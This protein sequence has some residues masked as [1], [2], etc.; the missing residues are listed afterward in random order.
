[1]LALTGWDCRAGFFKKTP[2]D[3]FIH[4]VVYKSDQEPRDPKTT[5]WYDLAEA[6]LLPKS[7][8]EI[9][10]SIGYLHQ[11]DLVLPWLNKSLNYVG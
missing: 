5:R 10:N 3:P 9:V 4:A 2:D 7:A 8:E 6:G 1:M 11:K